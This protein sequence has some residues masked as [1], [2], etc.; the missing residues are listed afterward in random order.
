[1]KGSVATV[2]ALPSIGNYPGDSWIVDADGH[3]YIWNGGSWTDAGTFEGPQGPQGIQGIQGIQG[4]TGPTGPTG[5][6]G[7]TGPQGPIGETGPQGPQGIQG[8]TGAQGPQGIQGIQGIQGVKGDTG[9]TGPQGPQG[10]P[11]TVNGKTGASIT[12]TAS[13]VG[14]AP[15]SGISPSAITGTAVVTSDS[16]LSDARTPTAHAVSHESG[17]TDEIEIAPAQVTGT[18]IVSGDVHL[19]TFVTSS[20]RPGSPTEGQI[21]YE[22]DTNLYYGYNGSNWVAVGGGAKG[23][24][25]DDIFFENGQTVTT[26][27]TITTSK[28]A[29]TAGPVS[30]NSGITVT[31]PSGSVWTV[32]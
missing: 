5:A 24:G 20:T 3:L 21:I 9:D 12:L 15:S 25:T 11:T 6:T 2:A 31:I 19:V 30:I 23:G 17:G 13:D 29:L 14:A 28:N 16:R 27:Y 1:V 18:A 22:T 26:N 7:A 32:V 10:D 4:E 8:E